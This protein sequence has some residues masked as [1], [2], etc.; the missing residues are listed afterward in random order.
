MVD[1]ILLVLAA[2]FIADLFFIPLV[3]TGRHGQLIGFA[4]CVAYFGILNSAI[5]GG[6]TIGKKL[7]RI[8]VVDL[9][10][11]LIRLDVSMLRYTVFALPLVLFDPP[12]AGRIADTATILAVSIIQIF[13]LGGMCYLVL[14]NTPSRRSIHDIVCGTCVI[15]A[16]NGHVPQNHQ[17]RQSHIIVMGVLLMFAVLS[18]WQ[19]GPDSQIQNALSLAEVLIEKQTVADAPRLAFQI[20]SKTEGKSNI[21]VQCTVQVF[22]PKHN[23][24]AL[25][26]AIAQIIDHTLVTTEKTA[27]YTVHIRYGYDIGIAHR[28]H[29]IDYTVNRDMFGI[30]NTGGTVTAFP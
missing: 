6:Q 30:P 17:L 24:K 16:S 22:D 23:N 12:L 3:N 28:W 18:P 10:G 4:V 20:K 19:T 2:N 1:Y 9:N 7:M 8:K 15:V 14:F 21:T 26:V 29:T 13:L 25:A 27:D 5:R 11:A